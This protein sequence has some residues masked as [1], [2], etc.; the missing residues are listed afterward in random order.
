MRIELRKINY[1]F[2]IFSVILAG[3]IMIRFLNGSPISEIY[4]R[5]FVALFSLTGI[6]IEKPKVTRRFLKGFVW[7]FSYLSLFILVNHINVVNYLSSFMLPVVLFYTYIYALMRKDQFKELLYLYEN[8][9]IVI[10]LISL[11]FWFFGSVLNVIPGAVNMNYTFAGGHYTTKNYFYVYFENYVQNVDQFFGGASIPRNCGIYCEVPAYS[12][13]L[14]Y[15]LAIELFLR[16]KADRRRLMIIIA[17][18]ITTQS[19]KALIII[20][21]VYG[22]M[23]IL[24]NNEEKS[25]TYIIIKGIFTIAAIV[26]LS[27]MI[28]Y[29]LDSKISSRSFAAR[30]NHMRA[31]LATWKTHP[32]F[33]VGFRNV[34][35]II[36]N[37]QRGIGKGGISMGLMILL[38]E[39]GLYLS[40]FYIISII[41]GF[42][43]K[44]LTNKYN[45]FIVT[46][47]MLI[48]V[49]ISNSIYQYP[50]LIMVSALYASYYVNQV[51]MV[52][53]VE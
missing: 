46:V 43:S 17:T 6:I 27:F 53:F 40:V 20:V 44:R 15:A 5:V 3:T 7:I 21:V 2:F 41:Q 39:G 36:E 35:E 51:K 49:F 42:R 50:Y 13:R 18:I 31:S 19:A 4:P 9:Y 37:Q 11:F 34:S 1:Y 14:L 8:I 33:G 48:N 38:A 23:I 22:L 32:L 16:E 47:M 29:V 26:L 24:S 28:W 10:C 12:G 52:S 30:M 25:R 45:L